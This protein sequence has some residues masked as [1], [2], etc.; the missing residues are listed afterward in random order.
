MSADLPHIFLL[1]RLTAAGAVVLAGFAIVLMGVVGLAR[2]PDLFT[3]AHAFSAMGGF[4]AFLI[5]IGLA[6]AAWAP[7]IS[8][9]LLVLAALLAATSGA[10]AHMTAGAAH[11]AGLAPLSG[12]YAAPR[13]GRPQSGRR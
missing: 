10:I 3:R 7:E 13:P 11:A 8:L 1:I 4:G 2:F 6:V 9:R 12:A 5:L